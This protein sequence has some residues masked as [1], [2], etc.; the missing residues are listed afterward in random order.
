MPRF[1]IVVPS[2][3]GR[4]AL[5]QRLAQPIGQETDQ[6]VSQD[7]FLFLMPDGTDLQVRLVD[8]EG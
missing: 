1:R 7:T 3:A 5:T 8:P 6:D 4:T 2:R